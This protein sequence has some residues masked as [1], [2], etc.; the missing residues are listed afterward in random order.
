MRKTLL[1]T[2][3]FVVAFGLAPVANA[4]EPAQPAPA[5]Q[6]RPATPAAQHDQAKMAKQTAEG[7]LLRVDMDAKT[8]TIKKADGKEMTFNY[9]DDTEITGAQREVA[10]LATV[11]G[12][13]V[14]VSYETEG[15][16]NDATKIE[17][18]AKKY[19]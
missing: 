3:A 12:S 16:K 1:I 7:E 5:P 9:S 8:V 14:T 6:E 18:K 10:G 4:Q 19:E 15:T 2:P 17:V 11:A 13:T